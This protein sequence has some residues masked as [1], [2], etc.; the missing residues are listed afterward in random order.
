M[1]AY[2]PG[3]ATL[4]H[5]D[6]ESISLAEFRSGIEVLGTALDDL[7]ATLRGTPAIAAG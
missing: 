4:D 6:D 1:A 5:S 2:G 7:G 3:D